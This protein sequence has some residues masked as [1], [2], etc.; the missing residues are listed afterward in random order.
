VTTLIAP[1][2]LLLAIWVVCRAVDWLP[3]YY[4]REEQLWM[5]A[6]GQNRGEP[7]Q[8]PEPH[9][10]TALWREFFSAAPPLNRLSLIAAGA[11]CLVAAALWLSLPS[12]WLRAAWF[13]YTCGLI[14][15]ALVD[16]QTKLLPDVLT[17]PLLWLGLLMQLLPATTSIG[18]DMAVIGAMLGY[19]PLWLLAQAYRLIRGRDGLGMGDLKLLAAMGAWSGPWVLPPVI[20]AAAL[21]AIVWFVVQRVLRRQG[22]GLHEEHPFGPWLIVAYLLIVLLPI[23][24]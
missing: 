24:R 1:I 21:L 5:A 15:L 23:S 6:V 4:A 8:P 11:I 7:F 22:G 12:G 13:V 17:I 20:F 18:L 10:A 16:H 2:A 14:T 19:L 3:S 9:T